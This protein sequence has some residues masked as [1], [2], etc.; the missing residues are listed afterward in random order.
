MTCLQ[1]HGNITNFLIVPNCLYAI[2]IDVLMELWLYDF[3]SFEVPICTCTSSFIFIDY[4]L[5]FILLHYVVVVI[6]S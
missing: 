3:I 1:F 6:V 5:L 2:K 4:S